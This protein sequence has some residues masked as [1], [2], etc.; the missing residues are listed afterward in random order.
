M[1]LNAPVNFSRIAYFVIIPAELRLD[2]IQYLNNYF[3]LD[4]TLNYGGSLHIKFRLAKESFQN[5]SSERNCKFKF[6]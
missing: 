2:L 1:N 5:V 4:L 3:A 6:P